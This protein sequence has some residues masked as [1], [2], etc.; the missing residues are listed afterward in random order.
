MSNSFH[1]NG[2]D[3]SG[4][5]YGITVLEA[6]SFPVS[7][8]PRINAPVSGLGFGGIG[9][10]V[11]YDPRVIRASILIEGTSA[12]NLLTKLDSIRYYLDP[13]QGALSVR[14]DDY[15]SDRYWL[16]LCNSQIDAP[17]LNAMTM[18]CELEFIAPDPRAY[19]TT[20]R[21]S[22]DF[23]LTTNPQTMTVESGPTVVAGTALCNPTWVIKNTSGG[24]VTSLTLNNTTQGESITWTGSLA[25]N[26]WLRI[27]TGTGG[28]V[29]K[30]TDSGASYAASIAGVTNPGFP[31]LK[32]QV[33]NSVT[34]TGI[35]GCTV[36]LTYTPRYL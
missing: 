26:N 5:T 14:F 27:T 24:T 8:A 18:Q 25:A 17:L 12:A 33:A 13:Q 9:R 10:F 19:S 2:T 22:P 16:A 29:E 15:E 28:T 4:S 23:T 21:S 31:R 1:F 7:A 30:S 20:A 11:G 36:V 6:T 35:A 3:M 32:P 34:L